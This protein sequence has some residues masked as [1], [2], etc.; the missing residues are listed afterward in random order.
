MQKCKPNK[1]FPPLVAFGHAVYPSNRKP[2]LR[3]GESHAVSIDH[4]ED[5]VGVYGNSNSVSR[6]V[7]VLSPSMALD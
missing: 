3:W 1:A 4:L 7:T 6:H 5:A 2:Y